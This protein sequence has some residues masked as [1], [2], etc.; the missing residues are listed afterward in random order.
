MIKLKP[1][2][3]RIHGVVL[4]SA[5]NAGDVYHFTDTLK[6][7]DSILSSGK[8][9]AGDGTMDKPYVCVGRSAPQIY[10]RS[11]IYG[12]TYGVILDSDQLS[13]N[14]KLRVHESY[15]DGVQDFIITLRQYAN[16]EKTVSYF[17]ASVG[18][19]APFLVGNN[20]ARQLVNWSRRVAEDPEQFY[21]HD[22]PKRTVDDFDV[23]KFHGND[24]DEYRYLEMG[25]EKLRCIV[26]MDISGLFTWDEL[27]KS[28]Q[29]V[30]AKG[31]YES[32]DRVYL[33]DRHK[34]SPYA[35]KGDIEV[36]DKPFMD[37]SRAI[38]GV[39]LPKTIQGTPE[40]EQFLEKWDKGNFIVK[41]YND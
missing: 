19:E 29:N 16:K 37:I 22:I 25:D 27:P 24:E 12:W 31:R 13:E 17:T 11:H 5:K 20:T 23:Y 14:Y 1:V 41:W 9:I 26:G 8:L 18:S 21:K 3:D 30:L 15:S 10:L 28:V 34:K 6:K 35:P 40:A 33:L 39:Y 32:E 4:N 38:K 36:F 2:P 7:L